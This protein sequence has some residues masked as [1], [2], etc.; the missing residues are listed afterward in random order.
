M[1]PANEETVLG[2]FSN[3]ELKYRDDLTSFYRNGD[4]FVVRTSNEADELEEYEVLY[5]FGVLPLQQYLVASSRGRMQ[6]L[7]FAWDTRPAGVGGQRWYSL[8]PAKNF[9]VYIE[10]YGRF[11]LTPSYDVISAYPI[12]G[13]GKNQL[14]PQ[15]AKLAM[16]VRGKERHYRWAEIQARHRISTAKEIGLEATAEEDILHM[17]DGA[18]TVAEMVSAMLPQGFPE[19]VSGPI[20]DGLLRSASKLADLRK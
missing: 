12:L 3:A 11:S 20:L 9:S 6:A 15:K 10:P 13:G 19:A 1:Q 4:K 8:Y 18:E 16:A 5:T 14:A 17:A 7:P 2:S